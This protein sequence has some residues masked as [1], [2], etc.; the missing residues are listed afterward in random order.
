MSNPF[1]NYWVHKEARGTCPNKD[2]SQGINTSQSGWELQR[3]QINIHSRL[4]VSK[5]G[6]TSGDV[7]DNLSNAVT[8][9]T[10]VLAA[11]TGF[12]LQRIPT[13]LIPALIKD[14]RP[15]F[16]EVYQMIIFTSIIRFHSS[17]Q[18]LRSN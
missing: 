7:L 3:L 6:S 16:A 2:I 4:S 18:Y 1:E 9:S 14:K 17:K 5:C 15:H 12:S 13:V 10:N 8:V 11:N